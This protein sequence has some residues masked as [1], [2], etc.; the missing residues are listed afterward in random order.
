M[1]KYFLWTNKKANI[2][3]GDQLTITIT[4]QNQVYYHDT[5]PFVT[6]F[7]DVALNDPLIYINS[8]VNVS[9]ALN[10]ASFADTYNIGTGNDWKIYLIKNNLFMG[11][12]Y[13]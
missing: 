5:I 12:N 3:R 11:E 8:L 2:K 1:D 10:Q 6:S 4:Y 9:I 7:A 13:E